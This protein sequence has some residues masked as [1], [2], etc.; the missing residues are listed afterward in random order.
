MLILTHASSPRWCDGFALLERLHL[1][2]VV[3]ALYFGQVGIFL[4]STAYLAVLRA[5]F[6]S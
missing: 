2:S 1:D 5:P 3:H 4:I 6:P